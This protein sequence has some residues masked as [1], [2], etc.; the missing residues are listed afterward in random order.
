MN[1]RKDIPQ[2]TTVIN[3]INKKFAAVAVG[4]YEKVVQVL[5]LFMMKL[6]NINSV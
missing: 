6:E 1:L 2:V 5:V 3:N 4:D